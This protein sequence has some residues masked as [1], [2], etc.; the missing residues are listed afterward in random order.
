MRDR[1]LRCVLYVLAWVAVFFAPAHVRAEETELGEVAFRQALLDL[2][3]DLRLMC[4]AAHPDDE[5]G[6][7]L[8]MYRRK[9]GYATIAVIATRGEGG[10]NEIGPELYNALGVI[11]TKEMIGA[12]AVTGAE[13]HF[14]NLPEFG[15]SKS[16]EEAFDVW[17]HDE[18][19][20]RL[21]RMIRMT[22]PDV[23]ITNHGTQKDHGHHQAIGAALQEAFDAAG[24][25]SRF[26]ELRD[27]GLEPWRPAE[28]YLRMWAPDSSTVSV[29]FNELEPWRGQTY[30]EIAAQALGVHK[31]QGMGFFIDRYL[32]GDVKASYKPVKETPQPAPASYQLAAPGGVLFE[33]RV[34]DRLH[35]GE[36]QRTEGFAPGKWRG[37][38]A[39]ETR[40]SLKPRLLQEVAAANGVQQRSATYERYARK[41]NRAAS[42]AMDVRLSATPADRMLVRGQQVSIAAT[43]AD[44]GEADVD[45]VSFR[46]EPVNGSPFAETKPQVAARTDSERMTAALTLTVPESAAIT[47]PNADHLFDA[48]FMEP[49]FEVVAKAKV[50]DSETEVELRLPLKV[51]IAPKVEVAFLNAPV[52]VRRGV[53]K[54][55]T[56][57]VL[58]TNRTATPCEGALVLSVAAGLSVE[59]PRIPFA[60]GG[61]DQQRIVSV[62]AKVGDDLQP[63][64]Y[65]INAVVEGDETPHMTAA[66]LVDIAVPENIN[67]GVIQS[68]DDT[69]VKTLERLHVPHAALG[70]GDLTPARLDRFSTIIVD[71]R[72]YLV[73]KDLVANN[74]ALLDY[75]ER[76]GNLIVMYQKTEE[77]R[78]EFAPY[79]IQLSRNRVTR[80]DAP[81]TLLTPEHPLFTTPNAITDE[82]WGGWIQER[83]LYFP[84]KWD[85]NYTPLI[86]CSDP[87][88]QIPPG[89]LLFTRFG[90][91]TYTYTA[92]VWYRQLRELH[93]GALRIFANMLAQ[94]QE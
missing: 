30:A 79:P 73:R 25:A 39:S 5:D 53:D 26:P 64:D 12:S 86:A 83:G 82:D 48:H 42:I 89:S 29:D 68:Y 55:T 41:L 6:G 94:D 85:A 13:L 61:E 18:T 75:V 78:P 20:K 69:F 76:G 52:L 38:D 90:K 17:G 67:V 84:D 7:T 23:I 60:I 24:D 49:Q 71:I 74:K 33:Q 51:D 16:P 40:A 56:F 9:F 65:L 93:P 92:L 44:F 28:L 14:L 36:G 81:I 27:E 15:F 80:E 45:T 66:R 72:A 62:A 47:V 32:Q 10:Q 63:R 2:G 91:G 54:E 22:Q 59:Q 57:D 8:A 3:T 70:I 4:V 11:R 87:G 77:W 19:V 58:L 31:S 37:I 35:T 1:L 88:E 50:K 46:L 43:L 21:V 34:A